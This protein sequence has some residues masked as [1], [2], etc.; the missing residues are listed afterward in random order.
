VSSRRTLILL[1]AIVLGVIAALLLFNYV[2]GIEDRANDNARRVDVFVAERDIPRGTPGETASGDGS[3]GQSQIP[4]EFL[5]ASAI[6]TTDE[7]AQ[8]VALFDI[9]ANSAIVRGMFVDPSQSQISFRQRLRNPDHVAITVSVDDVRGVAGFLVPGDEVNILVFQDNADV[10][11]EAGSTGVLDSTARYLYQKVQILAVG[12]STLLAPGEET[13]TAEGETATASSGLITFNVPPE[14]A[15]WIAS[16]QQG[17]GMYLSLVADD[18]QPRPLPPID[19]NV[20]ELP[21]ENAGQLTPYG[22]E[23]N[24]D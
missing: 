7:I 20:G 19:P 5:P 9:P 15:Q 14:A 17:G 24:Q 1:G 6:T 22:P 3:I 2:R 23:G 10:Q 13:A 8:K 4:Q 18:Y 16:A 12:Q 11:A 21:G